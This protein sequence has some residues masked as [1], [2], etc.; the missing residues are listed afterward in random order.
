MKCEKDDDDDDSVTPPLASLLFAFTRRV[1]KRLQ[2]ANSDVT[3]EKPAQSAEGRGAG[4]AFM[5]VQFEYFIN[6]RRSSGSKQ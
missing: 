4:L 3:D 1:S 5:L 2:C 6:E